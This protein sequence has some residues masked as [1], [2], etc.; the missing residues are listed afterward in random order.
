MNYF[1]LQFLIN[2]IKFF[3]DAFWNCGHFST[4]TNWRGFCLTTDRFWKGK[5]ASFKTFLELFKNIVQDY[6]GGEIKILKTD[7][8][9]R[10]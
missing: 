10:F 9:L 2:F 5:I 3:A 1:D 6:I 4:V 7:V 8:Y